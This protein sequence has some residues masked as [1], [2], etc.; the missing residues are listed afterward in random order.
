[1]RNI[2]HCAVVFSG[3]FIKRCNSFY[4]ELLKQKLNKRASKIISLVDERF[5]Q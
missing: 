5:L 1:M 4:S 3:L 2:R